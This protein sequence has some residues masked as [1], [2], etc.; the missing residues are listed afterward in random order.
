M[1]RA[2]FRPNDTQKLVVR[3]YEPVRV[4]LNWAA[5]FLGVGL[6]LWGAFEAGRLR[7]GYS[8]LSALRDQQAKA[9]EI[10]ALSRR[11]EATQAQLTAADVARRIDRDSY[12]QVERSLAELQ[13]RL[14]DQEKDLNFYRSVVHP[15]DGI[16]GMRIQRVKVLAGTVARHFRI[17]IVLVQAARQ[18]AVTTAAADF[19]VEG[20]RGEKAASL[21]LAELAAAA[22]HMLNF[23]FRY[24]QELEAEIVLPADFVPQTVQV[25]VRPPRGATPIRQSYEWK[26][27]PT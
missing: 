11:L 23:S 4:A 17:R 8:V 25:E 27:E 16:S 24:F 9:A 26:I 21:P 22:T 6:C 18:E 15:V 3:R 14:G 1:L 19:T 5:A 20:L 13:A 12:A 10:A 7:A 2:R